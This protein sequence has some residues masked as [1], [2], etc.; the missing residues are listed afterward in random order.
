[1]ERDTGGNFEK[2]PIQDS[3]DVFVTALLRTTNGRKPVPGRGWI[4]V[5]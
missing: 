5:G 3:S 1:M 2:N 4:E